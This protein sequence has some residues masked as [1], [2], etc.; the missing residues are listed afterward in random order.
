MR[1]NPAELRSFIVIVVE[2][3]LPPQCPFVLNASGPYRRQWVQGKAGASLG[4][5]AGRTDVW[6]RWQELLED[7]FAEADRRAAVDFPV[8]EGCSPHQSSGSASSSGGGAGVASSGDVDRRVD[9]MLNGR[10]VTLDEIRHGLRGQGLSRKLWKEH[11]AGLLPADHPWHHGTAH[12]LRLGLGFPGER[13]YGLHVTCRR[14][15][16]ATFTRSSEGRYLG[17]SL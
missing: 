17:S 7:E 11:W 12:P 10:T 2:A 6:T 1:A 4:P 9:P 16:G 14:R 8:E 5:E 13:P 15:A 3:S